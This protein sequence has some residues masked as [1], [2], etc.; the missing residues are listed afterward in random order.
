[1]E[2]ITNPAVVYHYCNLPT[3]DAIL[4][5]GTI[6]LTDKR[7]DIAK[8]RQFYDHPDNLIPTLREMSRLGL[9]EQAYTSSI[10]RMKQLLEDIV[11]FACCFSKFG[12]SPKEWFYAEDGNGVCLGFDASVLEKLSSYLRFQ[13]V[14]GMPMKEFIALPKVSQEQMTEEALADFAA[15]NTAFA[16]FDGSPDERAFRL[17]YI[18]SHAKGTDEISVFAHFRGAMTN[19]DGDNVEFFDVK[20]PM[21][22]ILKE[23]CIGP[24]CNPEEVNAILQKNGIRPDK[25][26]IYPSE[27]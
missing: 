18:G 15:E 27:N 10:D 17:V 8:L 5:N 19:R 2:N 11:V 21:D 13:Y 23:I 9:D 14:K 6:R 20:L 12:D 26:K 7:Y 4:T 25:V 16:K 24:R 22:A 1:M 3:L